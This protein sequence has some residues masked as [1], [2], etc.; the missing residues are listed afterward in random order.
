MRVSEVL[1]VKFPHASLV[2]GDT[3]LITQS[4]TWYSCGRYA[5]PNLTIMYIL[6]GLLIFLPFAIYRLKVLS[7]YTAELKTQI[8]ILSI[9][10]FITIVTPLSFYGYF[11]DYLFY[12]IAA[13]LLLNYFLNKE[14]FKDFK[15][16]LLIVSI[17]CFIIY[18]IIGTL[19][20]RTLID[21]YQ[22]NGITYRIYEIPDMVAAPTHFTTEKK[23]LLIFEWN[24]DSYSGVTEEFKEHRFDK[25][26]K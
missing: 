26:R 19:F 21:K 12:C 7:D 5:Q 17:I 9:I 11:L 10:S 20:G 2:A 16:A 23:S 1:K 13:T 25:K 15:T 22:K 6:K 4:R 3:D 8:I 18:S 24:V 14:K